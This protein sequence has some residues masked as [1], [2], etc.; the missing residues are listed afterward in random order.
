MIRIALIALLALGIVGCSNPFPVGP[1]RVAIK[2][3]QVKLSSIDPATLRTRAPARAATADR[4]EALE[5]TISSRTELLRYFAGWNRQVQ[6]RCA[7]EGNENGKRYEDFPLH[8]I[9]KTNS[10]STSYQYTIYAFIDLK[11]H[12]IE[13]KNGRPATTLDLKTER[14]ETLRCHL[15]GVTM[16]PVLFPRSNDV[17]VSGSTFRTLLQSAEN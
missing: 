2:L 13:Y 10:A 8:P 9:P 7:V 5:L 12:D 15:L 17:V 1:G 11:A 4:R 14:F 16:A 6:V 3:D